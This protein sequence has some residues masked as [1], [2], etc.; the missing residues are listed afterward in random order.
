MALAELFQF[1][2]TQSDDVRIKKVAP[3]YIQYV[4]K[5]LRIHDVVMADKLSE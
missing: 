4:N 2:H 5:L 1:V 3:V